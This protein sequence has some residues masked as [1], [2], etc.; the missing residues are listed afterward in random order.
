[1][2][3]LCSIALFSIAII[4][5]AYT[6]YG[7]EQ[8]FG[9]LGDFRLESGSMIK[10]CRIAY[11]VSGIPKADGSNVVLVPTW[12]AGTSRELVELGFVG[13]SGMIDTTRY[14]AVTVDAI[15]NGV[16]TS[17]SNSASQHGAAFPLFTNRDI[18]NAQYLLLTRILRIRHVYAVVGISMGGMQAFEWIV[19]HPDFMERA[20]CIQGTPW[21]TSYDLL[22]WTAEINAINLA[23]RCGSGSHE[24]M[25]AV[26][27]IHLISVWTPK[28]RAKN[29]AVKD[30][31]AFLSNAEKSFTKYDAT[32]WMWQLKALMRQDIRKDFG[33]SEHRAAD[34][35]KAK[36]L[37]IT[38]R[39]D[40]AVYPGPAGEFASLIKADRIELTGDCG[41]FSFLCET[42]KLKKLVNEFLAGQECDDWA[43]KR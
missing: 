3:R 30:F 37:V 43:S 24:T 28:Y 17:P 29:T 42:D 36:T 8:K 31:P 38:A 39:R 6:A 19:A 26:V 5:C 1:M 22:V 9:K 12:L 2:K 23:Q 13:P 27:P 10:D 33:G 32:D 34:A 21:M 25:R 35:V 11:R 41:H 20:V 15:G 40:G 14:C 18:V 4:F 7:R 16:S